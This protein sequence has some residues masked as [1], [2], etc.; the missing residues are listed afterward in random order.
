MTSERRAHTPLPARSYHLSVYA[1]DGRHLGI[2][3]LLEVSAGGAVL[4]AGRPWPPGELL[5]LEA[6]R[7]HPLAGRRLPFRVT[8]CEAAP[9]GG[10]RLAGSFPAALPEEDVHPLAGADDAARLSRP[11]PS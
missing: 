9:G 6:G 1:L 8:R 10:H 5:A 7:P 11:G 2:A 4:L 3:A